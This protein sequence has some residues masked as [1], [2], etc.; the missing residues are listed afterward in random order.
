MPSYSR[1]AHLM[2]NVSS[3]RSGSSLEAT[4]L[5]MKSGSLKST[6][7]LDMTHSQNSLLRKSSPLVIATGGQVT[8]HVSCDHTPT[9]RLQPQAGHPY[10]HATGCQ[11]LVEPH[12][13]SNPGELQTPENWPVHCDTHFKVSKGSCAT[14]A[15][16]ESMGFCPLADGFVHFDPSCRYAP[17][18]SSQPRRN[19]SYDSL[20]DL[21]HGPMSRNASSNSLG[22]P[23]SPG[24][25]SFHAPTK[26]GLF[27][28]HG[29]VISRSIDSDSGYDQSLSSLTESSK[30]SA[31]DSLMQSLNYDPDL[32]CNPEHSILPTWQNLKNETLEPSSSG[33]EPQRSRE[34][35]PSESR[36]REEGKR[37]TFQNSFSVDEY[38]N[39]AT[40]GSFRNESF[41][42]SS[43]STCAP[44]PS[45]DGSN[46]VSAY[47][48]S[49]SESQSDT[50]FIEGEV[51]PIS[52]RRSGAFSFKNKKSYTSEECKNF[53]R[54]SLLHAAP[55]PAQTQSGI[56]LP[57]PANSQSRS[58][59]DSRERDSLRGISEQSSPR[60]SPSETHSGVNSRVS[61]GGSRNGLRHGYELPRI[62][63]QATQDHEPVPLSD[64][65]RTPSRDVTPDRLS[66]PDSS[67]LGIP[68]PR[69]RRRLSTD[70]LGVSG[71]SANFP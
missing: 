69:R 12:P 39:A 61:S 32:H 68:I 5:K 4:N 63:R 16:C 18:T 29:P 8:S 66:C 13:T 47:T 49:T 9:T 67:H 14:L 3:L 27:S 15:S 59:S 56:E 70:S 35:C 7:S 43:S 17:E 11:H 38:S 55:S 57:E 25:L 51:T 19:C 46:T 6:R 40:A 44:N 62:V 65:R 37:A 45:F 64:V 42:D 48:N 23:M 30:E 71:G 53:T 20:S 2:L 41:S 33:A 34:A 50:V 22:L 24:P 36:Q 52:R 21:S 28:T 58:Q 26:T 60:C 31:T 54:G 1:N 10:T